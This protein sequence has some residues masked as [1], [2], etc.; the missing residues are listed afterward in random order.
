MEQ[1]DKATFAQVP[2]R[3]TGNPERPTEVRPDAGGAY[4]VGSSPIW[5]LGKGMLGVYLP[6][7]FRAGN[8]FHAGLPWQ[9]M[10]LGLKAMSAV[11][12]R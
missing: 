1:F 10:D 2:L 7:R 12:A 11:L 8:P 5:R 3:L 6:W 4:K 9:A